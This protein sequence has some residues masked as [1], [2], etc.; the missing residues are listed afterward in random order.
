MTYFKAKDNISGDVV[1]QS[2]LAP[3][4]IDKNL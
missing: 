2:Q 1:I 3:G 4:P